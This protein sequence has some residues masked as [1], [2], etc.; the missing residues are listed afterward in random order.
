[1]ENWQRPDVR[2]LQWRNRVQ[3][4]DTIMVGID[5]TVYFWNHWWLRK[6]DENWWLSKKTD[7]SA[8]NLRRCDDEPQA[9]PKQVQAYMFSQLALFRAT[10]THNSKQIR[11]YS[12]AV[13]KRRAFAVH[14]PTR[15]Q[16]GSGGLARR[17]GAYSLRLRWS[18][19]GGANPVKWSKPACQRWTC[20]Q[21]CSTL[22][23]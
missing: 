2:Q 11:T 20:R 13:L 19:S 23:L 22:P 12:T 3:N 4:R 1:M 15:C 9:L 17:T 7:G 8:G 14:L 5:T 21:S 16:S 18:W 6:T 10:L